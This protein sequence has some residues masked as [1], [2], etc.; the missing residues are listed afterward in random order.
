MRGSAALKG[1][2]TY[3]SPA[4]DS[5]AV[6]RP[7]RAAEVYFTVTVQLTGADSGGK[8]TLSSHAW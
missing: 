3:D 8:H 1:R 2:P 7:F 6:G 5:P 4:S